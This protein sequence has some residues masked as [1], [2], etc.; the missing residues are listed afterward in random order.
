MVLFLGYELHEKCLHSGPCFP[1][2]ELNTDRYSVSLCIQSNVGKCG[3][4]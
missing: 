2:F 1:A 3:P 4:E